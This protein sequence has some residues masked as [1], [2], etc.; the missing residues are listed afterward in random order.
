MISALFRVWVSDRVRACSRA[1]SVETPNS[2]LA[3][4][5]ALQTPMV[6]CALADTPTVMSLA[7]LLLAL[8]SSELKRIHLGARPGRLLPFSVEP[9]A[10]AS[11]PKTV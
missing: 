7:T 4:A 6:P 5:P 8:C 3:F 9:C 11:L 10:K 2:A 1:F